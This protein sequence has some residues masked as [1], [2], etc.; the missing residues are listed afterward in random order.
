[1]DDGSK[2]EEV[3]EL[4]NA[5]RFLASLR[6]NGTVPYWLPLRSAACRIKVGGYF[7]YYYELRV[8]PVLGPMVAQ[9]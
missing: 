6:F 1:M 2:R 5:S 7:A 8:L 3:G 9:Q 4:A